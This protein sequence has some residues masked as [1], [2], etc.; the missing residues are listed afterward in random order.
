M[1]WQE[2]V[3]SPEA[4]LKAVGHDQA[5]H[6]VVVAPPDPVPAMTVA[7]SRQAG[8]LGT[9][10]ANEL[11]RRLGWP[12]YDHALLERMA[13]EMR[14]QVDLLENVDERH[15]GWLV[16]RMEDFSAVPYV[17][18]NAYVRRL[19]ETLLALGAQGR[20]VIVG[21]GAAHVLPPT[22][23]LRVRLVAELADRVRTLVHEMG[24]TNSEAARRAKTLDRE[25]TLFLKDHF[26][27][28]PTCPENYDLTIN[29][30]LVPVD[31]AAEIIHAALCGAGASAPANARRVAGPT[32][33][34]GV[35]RVINRCRVGM[36]A[37]RQSGPAC[38][39]SVCR[40]RRF[41]RRAAVEYK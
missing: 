24:L 9:S 23:T 33:R 6:S 36:P 16:E 40:T 11:G 28:D 29:M 41:G 13:A 17:S 25:R 30:S 7:I 32:P 37:T 10:V 5:Q 31:G 3:R 14:V 34:L 39:S 2:S 20:S 18:E 4:L 8:A 12:V 21:R 22:T 26:H 35:C 38:P 27:I 19:I 1:N 15:V